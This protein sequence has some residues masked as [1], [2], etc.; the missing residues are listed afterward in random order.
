MDAANEDSEF[1]HEVK[2]A[3]NKLENHKEQNKKS[4]FRTLQHNSFANSKES[5]LVYKHKNV[6]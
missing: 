2:L 4:E 6:I 1:M 5:L 3:E